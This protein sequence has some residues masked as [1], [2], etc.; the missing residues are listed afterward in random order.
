MY[1]PK[2]LS[3]ITA[4]AAMASATPVSYDQGYDDPSRSLTAVSCS[5]GVNGVMWKYGWKVQGDA[6]SFVGGA[7]AVGG[8]NSP[9][10]GTCWSATWGGRTVYVLAIDRAGSGLNIGLNAMNQLTNGLATQVGVVEATVNQVALS[11]CGL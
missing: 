9:N 1:F 10:C 2:V 5:D 3:A 8:W 4:L 11:Y 7:A 6:K